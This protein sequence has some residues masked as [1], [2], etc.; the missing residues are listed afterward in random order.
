MEGSDEMFTGRTVGIQDVAHRSM[1]AVIDSRMDS[2]ALM[3]E[4]YLHIDY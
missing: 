2:S 1:S 4:N 3:C